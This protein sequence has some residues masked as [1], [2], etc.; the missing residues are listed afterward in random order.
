MMVLFAIKGAIPAD[1]SGLRVSEISSLLE[2]AAPTMT[3]QLNDL[4]TRGF[5]V[6]R[7]DPADRRAVRITLTGKG[8]EA[9]KSAHD[10]FLASY[11]GLV[12]YLGDD[13]SKELA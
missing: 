11:T 8:L 2:V 12:E 3:Q 10:A 9:L 7:G 1:G 4:E 5:V 6:R 13:D